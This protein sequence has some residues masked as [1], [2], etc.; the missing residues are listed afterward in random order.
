MEKHYLVPLDGSEISEDAIPWAQ[1]LAQKF[2]SKVELLRCC[3]PLASVY[4]VPEFAAP[5]HTYFDQTAIDEQIDEYLDSLTARLPEGLAIKT[6][7]EGDAGTAILD[8]AEADNIEAIVIASHGR[9]GIG[10]WL[11]GSVTTKVVRGGRKPVL[12]ISASTEEITEPKIRKVLLPLDGSPTS[13]AAIP[14]AV[15]LAAAFEAELV[16]YRGVSHTP[17]GNPTLDAA[18][19]F[20]LANAQDYLE[21]IKDKHPELNSTVAVDIASPSQGILSQAEHCDLV[22]MSSHG[23]SGVQRWLLGSVAEKVIQSA[24]TP[25]MIVYKRDE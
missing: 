9:G 24:T 14:K 18:V 16:L 12:V 25:V 10:R 4:M 5:S 6:R 21:E 7:C 19:K 1:L 8:Q 22:V 2:Q 3:E 15:E 17:I 23:R 20:E 13:E 11:L